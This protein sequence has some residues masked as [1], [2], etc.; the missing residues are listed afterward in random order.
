M[1]IEDIKESCYWCKN[2]K[3]PWAEVRMYRYNQNENRNEEFY[4]KFGGI[5]Y[6]PYCG[7]ELNQI[8]E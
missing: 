5:F 6:C 3:Q 8:S 2:L 4:H 1:D 7:K